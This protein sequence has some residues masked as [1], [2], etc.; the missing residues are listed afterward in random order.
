M[1]EKNSCRDFVIH[2]LLAAYTGNTSGTEG[3]GYFALSKAMTLSENDASEETLTGG[4]LLGTAV[5]VLVSVVMCTPPGSA[6]FERT[7]S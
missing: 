2:L 1:N 7:I 6:L 3:A 5:L 4:K